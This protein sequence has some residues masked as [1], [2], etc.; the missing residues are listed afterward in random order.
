MIAERL[1]RVAAFG[2]LAW[3]LWR[4]VHPGANTLTAVTDS[5][6]LRRA[7][8][9]W[10]TVEHPDA[11]HVRLSGVPSASERDWLASLPGAGTRTSWE[12]GTLV[13]IA[14]TA[15]PIADPSGVTVVR[16]AAPVGSRIA[17]ADV[18]GRLDSVDL[19]T[20][21]GATIV[22]PGAASSIDLAVGRTTARVSA[23]DSL[24]FKRI[25]V[26][27][28]A[29]WEAR[30]VVDALEERGWRVDQRVAF[31]SGRD[32]V[33]GLGRA[34]TPAIDTGRY[35]V[36]IALDTTAARDAGRITRYV[37]SGGGLVVAESA[38]APFHGLTSGMMTLAP[39]IMARRVGR[40]RLVEIGYEDTWRWRMTEE[41]GVVKHRSWWANV[42]SEAAYAPATRRAPRPDDDPAPIMRLADRLGP[43]TTAEASP[44]ATD[45][46]RWRPWIFAG[47]VLA[48]LAEWVIRRARG[49]R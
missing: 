37:A 9:Q 5:G 23:A 29:G 7:L 47:I 4:V 25:L 31:G 6:G 22:V 46:R 21:R 2:L 44:G 30:F 43:V 39:G 27:A 3:L 14:E 35:A 16:A 40:G 13:P 49:R 28:Q 36:V 26:L 24:D 34:D 11:V 19:G 42:V 38:A 33:A 1:L 41:S 12:H 18:A 8:V 32:V 48:L 45:E 20:H 10:S 17:L 15:E